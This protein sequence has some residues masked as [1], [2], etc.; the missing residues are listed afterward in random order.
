MTREGGSMLLYVTLIP[1]KQLLCVFKI[2]RIYIIN[3]TR[4]F[5]IRE[6]LSGFPLASSLPTHPPNQHTQF[7]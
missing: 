2:L 3:Q 5:T 6:H 1:D 4:I 7:L